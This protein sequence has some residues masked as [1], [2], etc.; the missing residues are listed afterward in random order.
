MRRLWTVQEGRLAKKVWFQFSDKALDVKR[1]Y[2]EL[3]RSCVPSRVERWLQKAIYLQLWVQIWYRGQR[4]EHISVTATA[5]TL[6]RSTLASRSVSVATDEAL[7][8]FTLMAKDLTQVTSVPPTQRMEV[9]WRSFQKV[10]IGFLF[11]RAVEKMAQK[12]LHWAPSSFLGLQSDK[13]WSGLVELSFPMEKDPHAYPTD[14]GLLVSLPGFT[15]HPA[16]IGRMK[17]FIFPVK[18]V[19]VQ[20][21]EGVWYRVLVEEPWRHGSETLHTSHKLAVI[22]AHELR[23]KGTEV[24]YASQPDNVFSLDDSSDGVLVSIV[25]TVGEVKYVTAH[26]HVSV[27]RWGPGYQTYFSSASRCAE[28]VNLSYEILVNESETSLRDRYRATVENYLSDTRI[29]DISV[30]RARYFGQNTNRE[31][32][33]DDLLDET[34]YIVSLGDCRRVQKVD[35]SQQWCV[36]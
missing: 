35:A 30:E 2:D 27:Y 25:R 18:S 11:S 7:C 10:P 20:D 6:I 29:L 19:V 33:V 4:M 1:V 8:L 9:F 12:G 13:E 32:I 3:D 14:S 36:D 26:S 5:I 28:D 24:P 15:L 17:A 22:L 34:L 23:D 16:L 31:S 21:E